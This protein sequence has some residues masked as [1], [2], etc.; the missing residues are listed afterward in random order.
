VHPVLNFEYGRLVIRKAVLNVIV[1]VLLSVIYTG[2][3]RQT[4]NKPWIIS[5]NYLQ[6]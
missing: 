1:F 2:C 5:M 6:N 4:K 3:V